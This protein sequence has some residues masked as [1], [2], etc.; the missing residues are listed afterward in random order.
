MYDRL[1]N[2]LD[3]DLIARRVTHAR[4]RHA[5]TL[6]R[7]G[8]DKSLTVGRKVTDFTLPNLDGDKVSLFELFDEKDYVLVDFWASWCGPC[9]ESFPA[10]K[11]L[12]SSYKE[13]GFEIVSVSID[14]THKL[15]TEGSKDHKL[16]WINLGELEGW[17]REVATAYGVNFIPKAYLVDKEGM[18]LQKDVTPEKLETFLIEE[19]GE[20]E[21]LEEPDDTL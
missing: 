11:N 16:P 3:A 7:E 8:N 13:H 14:E 6:A 21:S 15:W 5:Q 20:T 9:L 18:I 19:Y 12:Y 17:T 4:N 1:I 10:L 2:S